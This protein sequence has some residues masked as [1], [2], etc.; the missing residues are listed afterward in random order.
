VRG[1]EGGLDTEGGDFGGAVDHRPVDGGR[2]SDFSERRVV[3]GCEGGEVMCVY[4][5]GA[6]TAEELVVEEETDFGD[7][8]VTCDDKTAEEVAF[9]VAVE[10]GHRSLRA[11]VEV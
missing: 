2:D 6:V 3:G 1:F 11:A 7:H 4:F 10:L 9:G 5:G 8:V